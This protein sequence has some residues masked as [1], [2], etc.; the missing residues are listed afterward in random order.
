MARASTKPK[1]D[2]RTIEVIRR[3]LNEEPA[4]GGEVVET[5]DYELM[6]AANELAQD[7]DASVSIYRQIT[8]GRDLRFIDT[9]PPA[10][11]SL[12]M[13][14]HAPYNGGKFRIQ[15]RNAKGELVVNRLQ[16]VEPAPKAPEAPQPTQFFQQQ[17]PQMQNN[18]AFVLLAKAMT[19]GFSRIGEL[20]VSVRPEPVKQ[21]T[22]E[23]ILNELKLMKDVFQPTAT[24]QHTD[25]IEM[26]TKLVALTGEMG[27]LRGG[28]DNDPSPLGV[29]ME[30]ARTFGPNLLKAQQQAQETDEPQPLPQIVG[31]SGAPISRQA[32]QPRPIPNPQ[33]KPPMSAIIGSQLNFLV[34]Q[35]QRNNDPEPY[36][37]VVLENVPPPIME[38]FLKRPDWW[39]EICRYAPG[40][41][42]YRPW[43]DELKGHIEAYL[44]EQQTDAQTSP[45]QPQQNVDTPPN[46]DAPGSDEPAT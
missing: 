45:E 17:Q 9:I 44:T 35:A 2:D 19:D 7:A 12:V 6:A 15:M 13:L 23:E 25:P 37:V 11:F 28:G 46:A 5:I 27:G 32:T 42:N 24:V 29:L 14:K 31:P 10:N 33:G 18:D 4:D 20:V 30:L 39:E 40:A 16:E 26:L 3:A 22:T 36:A 1:D 38:S 34:R 41:S 8:H 21:R 43:F